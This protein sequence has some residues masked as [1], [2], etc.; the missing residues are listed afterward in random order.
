MTEDD[1]QQM[2]NAQNG[3]CAICHLPETGTS[4]PLRTPKR[5]SVDHDHETGV[6]RGLLCGPCN[7]SLGLMKD[8]PALLLAARDYL[9]ESRQNSVSGSD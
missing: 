7:T 2:A 1:Y 9:I 6:V 8:D 5:L 4:G 3:V